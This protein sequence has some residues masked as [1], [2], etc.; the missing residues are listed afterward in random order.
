MKRNAFTLVELLV[1]I[2]IIAILIALLLP[3]L[4][5]ARAAAQDVACKSNMRQIALAHLMY[6]ADNAGTLRPGLWSNA[7][8]PTFADDWFIAL[9]AFKY[10]SGYKDFSS[11]FAC[12]SSAFAMN[13]V[14]QPM[15]SRSGGEETNFRY[16]QSYGNHR[17]TTG[18][19]NGPAGDRFFTKVTRQPNNRMLVIE[20]ISGKPSAWPDDAESQVSI[21]KASSH[22]PLALL[23]SGYLQFRHGKNDRMNIAFIDGHV[24]SCTR[25]QLTRAILATYKSDAWI[26][27]LD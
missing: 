27:Q 23:S 20:K 11:V 19:Q 15:N 22:D 9:P 26:D 16:W 2:G 14:G 7:P 8:G 13:K 18:Q 6:T 17:A 1:V 5:K 24:T 12:P 4:N 25:D 21:R 3:A 10:L